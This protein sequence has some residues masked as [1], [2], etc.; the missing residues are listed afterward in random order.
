[1]SHLTQT[2]FE[3]QSLRAP[4]DRDGK[5]IRVSSGGLKGRQQRRTEASAARRAGKVN[6]KPTAKMIAC[7]HKPHKSRGF[8]PIWFGSVE[9]RNAHRTEVHGHV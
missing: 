9:S 8:G 7:C 3:I 2:Q 5:V 4:T 6:F 1:M